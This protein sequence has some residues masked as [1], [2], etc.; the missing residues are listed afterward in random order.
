[1][2]HVNRPFDICN[3]ELSYLKYQYF[4]LRHFIWVSFSL[5]IHLKTLDYL[6]FQ[7]YLTIEALHVAIYFCLDTLPDRLL[8]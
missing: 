5:K 3:W 1:M 7:W 2:V 8:L 4:F 6:I